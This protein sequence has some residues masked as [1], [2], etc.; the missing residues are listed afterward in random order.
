MAGVW[1]SS[2]FVLM[3]CAI[4]LVIT[5]PVATQRVIVVD[6]RG[7]GDFQTIHD[8]LNAVPDHNNDP[9][10]IK[11]NP[12]TYSYVN[13]ITSSLEIEMDTSISIDEFGVVLA[14]RGWWCPRARSR[15][16]CKELDEMSR[17]S[18]PRPPL[19]TLARPTTPPHSAS[20]RLTSQPETSPSR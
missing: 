4:S 1:W 20:V 14:E 6:Q 11:V 12:G 15:S 5:S 18:L 2:T 17:K 10:T 7:A 16:P 19:W 9:I 8:A 13:P 3:T